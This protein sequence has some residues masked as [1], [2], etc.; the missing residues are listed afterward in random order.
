MAALMPEVVLLYK[1][2]VM[3]INWPAIPVL[4]HVLTGKTEAE[5]C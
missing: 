4:A 5:E 3:L 2:H 1:N